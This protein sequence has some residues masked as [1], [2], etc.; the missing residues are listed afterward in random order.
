[1]EEV[2]YKDG[3]LE[4]LTMGWHEKGQKLAEANYK[5]GKLISQKWWDSKGERVD[6]YK[7]AIAE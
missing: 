5:D 4:G 6:S 3:K 7:E 1:M 2:N